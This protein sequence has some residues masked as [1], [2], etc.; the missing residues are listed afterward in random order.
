MCKAFLLSKSSLVLVLCYKRDAPLRDWAIGRDLCGSGCQSVVLI[1]H[2]CSCSKRVNV[3]L[4]QIKRL[5][6]LS[7]YHLSCQARPGL[8]FCMPN[9]CHDSAEAVAHHRSLSLQPFATYLALMKRSQLHSTERAWPHFPWV[10]IHLKDWLHRSPERMD[11][12]LGLSVESCDCS[13][14][15][16]ALGQLPHG[17]KEHACLLNS[18]QLFSAQHITNSPRGLHVQQ[19]APGVLSSLSPQLQLISLM[20]PA[21]WLCV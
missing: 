20:S 8:V 14:C 18:P 5:Q 3:S 9:A 2:Q 15:L 10:P 7:Q 6:W 16:Q 17:T 12:E 11:C 21:R 4:R 19:G 13:A 1:N